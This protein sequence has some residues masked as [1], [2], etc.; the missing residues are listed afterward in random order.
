MIRRHAMS[1]V[2]PCFETLEPRWLL[3]VSDPYADVPSV[4]PTSGED[5]KF[6]TWSGTIAIP[7]GPGGA[8]VGVDCLTP[9]TIPTGAAV[10]RVAV[11]YAI[12]HT[13]IG[14]LQVQLYDSTH[15][16]YVRTNEG[17]SAD[18]INETR[19][20]AATFV[21]DTPAQDWH[22][23][24]RDTV[25]RDTGTLDLV[26]LTVYYATSVNNPPIISGVPNVAI[27]ENT[28][29]PSGG[30][31]PPGTTAEGT[32]PDSGTVPSSSTPAKLGWDGDTSGFSS[33][34]GAL[35]DATPTGTTFRSDLEFGGTWWDANKTLSNTQD[36]LMCWAAASSNMLEWT[37]WGSV[38]GLSTSQQI[39]QYYQNHWTDDGGM[40]QYG[41]SWWFS[42]ANPSQGWYGWSQV[43][44]AGGGFWTGYSISSYFHDQED[45]AQAMTAIDQYC[46][47]GYGVTLGIYGPG[48]HAI[49]VW[50]FNYNPSNP[51]QYYGLWITDSDDD[52]S[53]NSPPD[54]LRY[55]EVAQSGGR[56]YLQNYYG[57]N[58]WYIGAVQ[59]LD[60]KPG[61][62]PTPVNPSDVDLWQYASDAE[63]PSDQLT[64]TIVGNTNPNCGVSISG[65]RYID[66]AP[67]H[68]WSG[69]SYVTVQVSDGQLSATDTF[70]VTVN[71]VNQPPT[72]A[73]LPDQSLLKNSTKPYA[74]YLPSYASD[75]ETASAALSYAIVGNTDLRCGASIVAGAYISLAPTAGWTGY[76]D[77]TVQVSDGQ[78]IATDVFRV[79]VSNPVVDLVG[80]VTPIVMGTPTG[81][82]GYHLVQLAVR[83][84]GSATASSLVT[85]QL[86]ASADGVLGSGGDDY[87]LA[88]IRPYVYLPSGTTGYYYFSYLVPDNIPAGTYNLVAVVDSSND[89]VESNESNNQAS[90][91]GRVVMQ[92][93]DLTVAFQALSLPSTSRGSW[94]VAVLRVN[95]I[96][97]AWAYGPA[98]LQVWASS[99]GVLGNG[100]GDTLLA[101][102]H[103]Y[104]IVLPPI[105]GVPAY[106]AAVFQ[107]PTGLAPGSYSIMAVV[108]SSNALAETNLFN[109]TAASASVY[110]VTGAPVVGARHAVPVLTAGPASSVAADVITPIVAVAPSTPR[111]IPPSVPL[112]TARA[113][114]RVGMPLQKGPKEPAFIAGHVPSRDLFGS[115]AALD[116]PLEA[117]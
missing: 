62:T 28:T 22:F 98:D 95:N 24:V 64:Y 23:R 72:I 81:P 16:W 90:I 66:L 60:R 89:V 7:E 9:G 12:T 92:N 85:M 99:D 93:P 46:R 45:P 110:P 104:W 113:S 111:A 5:N 3:S 58:S 117:S 106:Y 83:N 109:N 11:H 14:D 39:F 101:T 73:G 26:E 80:T 27:D 91:A 82:M 52:K 103:N 71:P 105:A 19:F 50:G 94:G 51:T 37:G 59:A 38:T 34:S 49:T 33:A 32:V 87:K 102:L 61:S 18:N 69:V 54:R 47:A 53:S 76:S 48:G 25:E 112:Q 67:A 63:T 8:W 86:W 10:T 114:R 2:A 57:T 17:G 96:G 43:D 115:L 55:Y 116:I 42:G 75:P 1:A 6:W 108:N 40:M 78:Y 31:V 15:T 79:T 36:D 74:V 84:S 68:D 97:T 4:T 70:R 107:L 30:T 41:W 20:D 65:N 100:T 29:F 35:G 13:Y 56:W 88:E 44:V 21:G 77:V